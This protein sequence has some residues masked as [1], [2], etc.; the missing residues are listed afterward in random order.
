[1]CVQNYGHIHMDCS[2]IADTLPWDAAS[3]HDAV[4]GQTGKNMAA[5]ATLKRQF[6]PL[7]TSLSEPSVIDDSGGQVM[8]YYLPDALTSERQA[9]STLLEYDLLDSLLEQKIIGESMKTLT[10]TLREHWL[11][12]TGTDGEWRNA[13]RHFLPAQKSK[14]YGRGNVTA[15]PAWHGQAKDVSVR[16]F[17]SV[18]SSDQS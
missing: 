9:G 12:G 3:Y 14:K 15:S 2:D 6:P 1:M 13:A 16:L 7:N 8:A 11:R 17:R 18:V 10:P 4:G 5:E